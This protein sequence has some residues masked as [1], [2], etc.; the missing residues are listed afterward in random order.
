MDRNGLIWT[1]LAA[2]NHLASFDRSKCGPIDR[3]TAHTGRNC[4]E[5]WTLYP[6]PAPT[7]Q[8]TDHGTDFY[9]YNYVDQFDTLGFGENVPIAT[10]T[11]SDSLIALLPE[12]G[13]AVTMRVPYPLNGFHPRGMDGRIDDPDAG[14]KGRGIYSST[15][16]STVWHDEDALAYENGQWRSIGK[17]NIVKFQIRP[18]PLAN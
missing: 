18:D 15:A 11:G 5:G 1:A 8:G 4:A 6:L 2:S 9:Y 7:F 10:G 12:T 14:W 3:A 13:E 17:P 16:S